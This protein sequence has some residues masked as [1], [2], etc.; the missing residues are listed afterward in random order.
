MKRK[1]ISKN[2]VLR[3]IHSNLG[4]PIVFSGKILDSILE[5]ITEGLNKNNKVKISGFGTFKIINKKSRIGRNP[6]SQ[7]LYTI[8][9]RK[10]VS[11]YPS[12]EV[13]RKIN[14]KK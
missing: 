4:I 5:I 1:N 8:K 2:N 3:E 11:F 6:K 7:E 9:S 12:K 13:R 14:D 10:V